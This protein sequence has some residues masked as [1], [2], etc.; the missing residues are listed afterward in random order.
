ME[1]NEKIEDIKEERDN[2]RLFMV[3]ILIIFLISG[4]F[5][6]IILLLSFIYADKI[7][8][9]LLWC[10][11]TTTRSYGDVSHYSNSMTEITTSN[12]STSTCS[13]N[14]KLINCSEV[15]NYIP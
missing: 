10:T 4:V 1:E 2:L 7:E 12:S 15:D 3:A 14:G 13:L 6:G 8:C 9:N 5:E 11:F